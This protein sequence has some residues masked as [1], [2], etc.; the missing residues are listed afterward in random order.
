MKTKQ[1]RDVRADAVRAMLPMY[2]RKNPDGTVDI[3]RDQAATKH[4]CTFAAHLSNKPTRRNQYITL[5]CY[6]WALVWLPDS[7]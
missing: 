5:N 1:K 6:R 7:E 2:A 4:F 3:Y